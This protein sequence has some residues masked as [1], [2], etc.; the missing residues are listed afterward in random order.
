MAII[1]TCKRGK[2]KQYIKT[3]QYIKVK[4]KG[5]YKI[6]PEIIKVK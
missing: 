2:V 5:Y 6:I 4:V 3:G 1:K